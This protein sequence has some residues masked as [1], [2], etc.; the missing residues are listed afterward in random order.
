MWEDGHFRRTTLYDLGLR[1]SVGHPGGAICPSFKPGISTF[2]VI[3]V[4]G[5][6]RIHL[7][8]CACNDCPLQ[9]WQQLMRAQ[10]WPATVTDPQTVATF[11]CLRHFEKVNCS[12]H[13]TATGYYRALAHMTDCTGLTELPVCSPLSRTLSKLILSLGL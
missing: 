13:I 8:Y 3:H 6:H 9:L 11:E 4:N 7:D 5:L 2:T 12:G 10:W 1:V